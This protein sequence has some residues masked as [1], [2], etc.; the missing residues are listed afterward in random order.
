M[1]TRQIV[2]EK[3]KAYL[4]EELTLGQLVEWAEN[5]MVDGAFEDA[6]VELLSEVVGRI[7]LADME[8]FRLAWE[9]IV[10]MLEKLGYRATVALK[11]S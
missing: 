9:D 1:V 4:N 3:L 2:G 11:T 6:H 10:A 5:A 8:D 7:G